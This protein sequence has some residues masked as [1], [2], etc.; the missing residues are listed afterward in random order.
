VVA[1]MPERYPTPSASE[2]DGWVTEIPTKQMKELRL[3]ALKK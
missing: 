1:R 2:Q 3:R